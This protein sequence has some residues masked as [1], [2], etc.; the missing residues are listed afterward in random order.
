M[1]SRQDSLLLQADPDLETLP[2][3]TAQ[4]NKV[5]VAHNLE[6]VSKREE[7]LGLLK[8]LSTV[9]HVNLHEVGRVALLKISIHQ[10]N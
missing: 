6:I 7:E 2:R 4:S 8:L 10:V 3:L 1:Q 5:S 9:L